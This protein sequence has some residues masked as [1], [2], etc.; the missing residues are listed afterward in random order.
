MLDQ[1]RISS[2]QL[3]LLLVISEAAT[4]FL[5]APSDVIKMA[6]RDSWLTSVIPTISGLVV[7][8]VCIALAKRFPQQVFTEYLPKSWGKSPGKFWLGF[9]Q[10]FSSI[11]AV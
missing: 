9:T 2:V 3:F 4:A 7:A 5:Y 11:S 1:G 8:V 10:R 6:G